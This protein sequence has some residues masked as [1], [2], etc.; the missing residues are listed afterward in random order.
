MHCR[1]LYR[2]T[3]TIPE[4]APG[5]FGPLASRGRE[6][7]GEKVTRAV[8]AAED[9]EVRSTEAYRVWVHLRSIPDGQWA[10]FG[11]ILTLPE[12]ASYSFGTDAR[13][14]KTHRLRAAALA[15]YRRDAR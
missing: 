4:G 7:L 11:E 10:G 14:S 3:V 1:T 13:G 9:T 2:V 6:L 5:V 12:L 8:L 15:G